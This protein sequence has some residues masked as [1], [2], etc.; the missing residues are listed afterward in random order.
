MGKSQ[1][2]LSSDELAE[3]QKN[4]YCEWSILRQLTEVDKKVCTC[5]IG[6][7][8]W[9]WLVWRSCKRLQSNRTSRVCL[10]I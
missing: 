7:V 2:K 5:G 10:D 6:P 8:T 3:L 4:T 9:C 1:S